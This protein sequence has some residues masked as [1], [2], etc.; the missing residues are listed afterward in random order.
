[1]QRLQYSIQIKPYHLTSKISS[2][3]VLPFSCTSI[4]FRISPLLQICFSK[5]LCFLCT[6][7]RYSTT[8]NQILK[9]DPLFQSSGK[10]QL[11]AIIPSF[12]SFFHSE[13]FNSFFH[14]YPLISFAEIL[15]C[16]NHQSSIHFFVSKT[17]I[18]IK[19]HNTCTILHSF[20]CTLVA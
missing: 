13:I 11:S 6:I 4:T 15:H 14:Y 19:Q 12:L 2:D 1:M 9:S 5:S 8:V 18:K 3:L 7:S 17:Q 16:C 10:L 20:S